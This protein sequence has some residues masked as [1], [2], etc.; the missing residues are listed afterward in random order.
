MNQIELTIRINRKES[1]IIANDGQ[2]LGKLSL[3]IYDTDSILNKYGRYGNPYSPTSI[4]NKYSTYGSPYSS[5]SPFNQYTNTPPIIF[6]HGIKVGHLSINQY[7]AG[8]VNPYEI[9]DWMKYNAL[10]Y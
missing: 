5:L 4:M 2:F 1:F 10:Y 6:L 3:N 8:A 7:V 9:E